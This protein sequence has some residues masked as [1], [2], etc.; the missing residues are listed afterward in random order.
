MIGGVSPEERS[1]GLERAFACGSGARI[2][3]GPRAPHSFY[4]C[5][6][7]S[8]PA[9]N[10]DELSVF[11]SSLVTVRAQEA[12]G[13]GLGMDVEPHSL[14]TVAAA[15]KEE[16]PKYRPPHLRGKRALSDEE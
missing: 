12:M 10:S 8:F 11:C 5:L 9:S 13:L 15:A 2:S 14:L 4:S 7:P 1:I 3:G 16:L 6:P